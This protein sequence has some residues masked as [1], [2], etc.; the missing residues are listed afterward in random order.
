M[1]IFGVVRSEVAIFEV[2]G[3]EVT[4][5]RIVRRASVTVLAVRSKFALSFTLV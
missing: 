1:T 3:S 5:F 4:I 2:V